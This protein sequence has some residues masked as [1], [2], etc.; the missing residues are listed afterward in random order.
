ME[1]NMEHLIDDADR[2]PELPPDGHPLRTLGAR[3]AEL[4]DEDRFAECENLVLKAWKA[5]DKERLALAGLP[6]GALDCGWTAAGMSAY[7]KLLEERL[8]RIG[9]LAASCRTGPALR[10]ALAQIEAMTDMTYNAIVS[11]LPRK[12]H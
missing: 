12:W 6:E 2:L 5:G 9:D 10:E 7:A 11:G 8:Q 4:L 1:N 3:L